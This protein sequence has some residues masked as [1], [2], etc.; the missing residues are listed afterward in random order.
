MAQT[1]T[2]IIISLLAILTIFMFGCAE[3]E[4]TIVKDEFPEE[5]EPVNTAPVVDAGPDKEIV[6][7]DITTTL[8]AEITD[9]SP[10]SD[11]SLSWEKISGPGAVTFSNPEIST[12]ITSFSAPGDYV[13]KIIVTDG[14]LVGTDEVRVKVTQ[15]VKSNIATI[16]GD[17]ENVELKLQ[18]FSDYDNYMKMGYTFTRN[19]I[20]PVNG[21]GDVKVRV[22]A[23]KRDATERPAFTNDL[24]EPVK[25]GATYKVGVTIKILQG[26]PR[27]IGVGFGGQKAVDRSSE[28][29]S[30]GI[31][32][33]EFDI[34]A[35]TT[36][37]KVYLY[38]EGIS[39]NRFRIDDITVEEI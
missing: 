26:E 22:T 28:E 7:P 13:I 30:D 11:I 34:K 18:H 33:Y 20:G 1:K 19:N 35:D 24:T 3:E 32:R 9:D 4:T 21:D 25:Q 27:L 8:I 10:E 38:F 29:I 2:L 12:T 16:N 37:D 23:T 17:F 6:L 15:V 14:D 31:T 36:E 5:P 39:I